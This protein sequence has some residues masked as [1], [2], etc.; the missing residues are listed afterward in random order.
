MAVLIEGKH[1]AEFIVSEANNTRSREAARLASGNELEAGAVLGQVTTASDVTA[2]GTNVGDGTS[3]ACTLGTQAQN[4]TYTLT[5][6]AESANAGTFSVVAPNGEILADLTVAVAY[7][8]SHINLTIADGTEDFD[9]GDTF[10]VDAIFG[11]YGEFNPAASDG[12]QTAKAILRSNVDA[13]SAEQEC[14]VYTRDCEVR[15]SDLGWITG[16]TEVQKAT[17]ITALTTVGIILR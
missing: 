11:E 14:V 9:I 13:S 6:T 2:G 10:T 8:S 12:T 5:C 16:I 15:A 7:V 17:A 4:G 1:D 3:G